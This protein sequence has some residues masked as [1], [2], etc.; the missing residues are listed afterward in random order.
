MKYCPEC[1]AAVGEAS[2]F[3]HECGMRLAPATGTG[4]NMP[5]SD[6]IDQLIQAAA[7]SDSGQY[8]L[9]AELLQSLATRHPDNQEV[10]FSLGV[11][12]MRL[13]DMAGAAAE[14]ETVVAAIPSNFKAV[15]CLGRVLLETGMF[16]RAIE[17]YTV[18]CELRPEYP[19]LYVSLGD[20]YSGLGS[21]DD[22]ES[23]YQ[24]ALG[25]NPLHTQ[26]RLSL[27][28]LMYEAGDYKLAG[29]HYNRAVENDPSNWKAIRRLAI[30]HAAR[31]GWHEAA[32]C[33]RRAVEIKPSNDSL[34]VELAA[35]L[36]NC[37]QVEEAFE[38]AEAELEKNPGLVSIE[39]ILS[40][41]FL[42]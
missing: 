17:I 3:C 39:K 15:S 6:L 16:E 20:A 2:K 19:D 7:H 40:Y 14:F 33:L 21:R 23:C 12:Y 29:I 30:S 22:A 41:N 8:G 13:G 42:N 9:A 34:R 10:R 36:M 31:G 18:A 26:A 28:D 1:G 4:N 35:A 25:V 27:G 5:E 37:G 11:A 32:D 38:L 24:K